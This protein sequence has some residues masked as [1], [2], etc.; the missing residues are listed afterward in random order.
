MTTGYYL[1]DHPPAS[2]QFRTPRRAAVSGVVVVHT[3]EAPQQPGGS[4]GTA[5]FI[6]RRPDPG[7]YHTIVDSTT[8]TRLV[9]PLTYEVWGAAYPTGTNS[10]ALHLAFRGQ[11][12]RWGQD[13]AYD[14]AAIDRAGVE[15]AGWLRSLFGADAARFVRWIDR[16]GCINREPG[17][18]EHGTIQP[19]DRVDPWVRLADQGE[20]RARLSHAV[21]ANLTPPP[22]EPKE[23]SKMQA[24]AIDTPD[25]VWWL[26][27]GQT[28]RQLRPGNDGVAQARELFDK[29]LIVNKV[30]KAGKVLPEYMPQTLRGAKVV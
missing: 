19:E 30:D 28:K 3:D 13:P 6:S 12:S 21:L 11:R 15:I 9:P 2:S 24:V 22:P 1:L 14:A 4:V 25:T 27:D 7:S 20:F 18:V 5:G 23:L 17:L 29:G 16:Q 26:T 10:H 8:T